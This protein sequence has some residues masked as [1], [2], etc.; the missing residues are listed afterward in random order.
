M[1]TAGTFDD[2]LIL[3]EEAISGAKTG[4]AVDLNGDDMDELNVRIIAPQKGTSLVVKIQGSDDK[5]TWNDLYTFPAITEA[6]EYNHKFRGKGRWRRA[7]ITASG[8]WG[9]VI[10]GYSTGGVL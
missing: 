3:I 6:G 5:T 10:V 1:K 8:N 2:K 4:E 7:V 9:N